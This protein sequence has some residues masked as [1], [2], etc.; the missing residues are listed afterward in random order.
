M[1]GLG[2]RAGNAP[3]EEIVA[4]L[5]YLYGCETGIDRRQLPAISALV[6]TASRRPVPAGKSIV[7]DARVHP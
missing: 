6:A 3:L 5:A 7:G 4:A 2:E 1:N